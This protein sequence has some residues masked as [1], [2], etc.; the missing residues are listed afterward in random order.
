MAEDA[1][2]P[3]FGFETAYSL[4]SDFIRLLQ[5]D[6]PWNYN[7]H[8]WQIEGKKILTNDTGAL[9][10]RYIY[11]VTDPNEFDALFI[12]ALASRLAVELCEELTQSNTKG[13]VVRN[14]YVR[15]IREARKLNSFENVPAEQQT[16]TWITA[17]I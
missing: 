7:T 8:D 1:T 12:E 9:D 5:P 16:D 4:P 13:E 11:R 17:R 3:G 10:V 2:D 15:A 14:D 6:P